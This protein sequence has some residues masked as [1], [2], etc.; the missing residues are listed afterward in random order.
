MYH[1]KT[2][3]ITLVT[4]FFAS[5]A[6]LTA[7]LFGASAFFPIVVTLSIIAAVLLF[8][9]P[10]LFLFA[11]FFIRM[12]TDYTSQNINA[13]FFNVSFSLSQMLGIGIAALGM[14]FLIKHHRRI[15]RYPLIAAF[16]V[17]IGWGCFSLLFSIDIS[18]TLSDIIR[19][20]DIF[21]IG[22][23][24][25]VAIQNYADFQKFIWVMLCSSII[26]LIAGFAQFALGIGLQDESV[27]FARIFG[28]FAHPNV[29]SLY[30][31][32]VMV[33]AS[34]FLLS[35]ETKRTSN[36]RILF[37]TIIL[38][39]STV[40]LILTF[41][42]VAWVVAFLFFFLLA[43]W[44]KPLLLIPVICIPFFIFATSETFQDRVLQTFHQSSNS[45]V[46]WRTMIWEDMIERTQS[47]NRTIYGY[48]LEAF[49][50]AAE[51]LRGTR[52]GSNEAHNDYVKFFVEGGIIGLLAFLSYIT[53]IFRSMYRA[54]T[55]TASPQIRLIFG[56][57]ILFL[58]T[59]L[60]A[61]LSDNI[62]KNTPLW[63]VFF[64]L[65]GGALSL[66]IPTQRSSR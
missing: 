36:I 27:S 22:C 56:V 57:L 28:T 46:S 13:Q 45:S 20:F 4:L 35:T 52:F 40:M 14:P 21:V 3:L 23:I 11:L 61:A 29:Y 55:T 50:R 59:I 7:N 63:W 53:L 12:I 19:I 24:A 33:C 18:R 17:L 1:Q 31:F 26:P 38:T 2:L 25:F 51:Q 37:G 34:L 15:A 58:F 64:S 39:S 6:T 8:E 60:I 54:Y 41:A 65:L 49:P 10:L 42:R 5:L 47:E 48:G 9:Q 62:F 44:K 32:S 66:T 43:L 16:S 30:L